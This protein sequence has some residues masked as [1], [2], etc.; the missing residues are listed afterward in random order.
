MHQARDW[1]LLIVSFASI[2]AGILIPG[3]GEPLSPFPKYFMMALLF[4][5]F[6]S[7]HVD[8]VFRTFRQ[9]P[10]KLSML[11]AAKLLFL[12]LAVYAI[13]SVTI[14]QYAL[15]ALLLSGVSTGVVSPFF[16]LMVGADT[17]LVLSMVVITS[18]LVP[19]TLPFLVKTLAGSNLEI[20]LLSMTR[21]LSMVVFIPILLVEAVRRWAPHI[22]NRLEEQRY[23][24]SLVLFAM[25]NLGVFARYSDYLRSDPIAVIAS[26][27]VA[28]LLAAVCF[29]AGLAYTW[30]KPLEE[31]L[32]V[33]ICF[34]VMNNILVLVFSSEFFGPLETVVAAVYSIPFYGI[35]IPLR[36]YGNWKGK[37]EIRS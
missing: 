9:E 6:V 4:L 35:L 32:S 3:L 16:S 25:T 1:I 2:A 18:F 17:P 28:V 30:G 23:A 33:I 27:G 26:L 37:G 20:S 12:P 8:R 21:L 14:P 11:I 24:A 7:I 34:Y 13:F 22:L 5:S 10:R 15:A 29:W 31:Q 36:F 19:F